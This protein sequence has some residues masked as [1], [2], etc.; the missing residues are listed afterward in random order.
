MMV[1]G[2]SNARVKNELMLPQELMKAIALGAFGARCSR[3]PRPQRDDIGSAEVSNVDQVGLVCNEY[4]RLLADRG[5][6]YVQRYYENT[7]AT[8]SA[9]LTIRGPGYYDRGYGYYRDEVQHRRGSQEAKAALW[10]G[11]FLRTVAPDRRQ[12]EIQGSPRPRSS[13]RRCRRC[14]NLAVKKIERA[15]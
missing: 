3:P 12:K 1:D 8:S 13:S 15:M 5:P 7:P 2:R 11:P 10:C 9:G 4:G 6:A 14:N